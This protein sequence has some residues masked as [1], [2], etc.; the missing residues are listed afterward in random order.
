MK[1]NASSPSPDTAAPRRPF[2]CR[3]CGEPTPLTLWGFNPLGRFV[4][5]RSCSA[6]LRI[7]THARTWGFGALFL[8]MVVELLFIRDRGLW[9][10]RGFSGL[11]VQA[12]LFLFV[13]FSSSLAGCLV[14][15]K[16][17]SA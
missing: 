11:F 8:V 4:F 13:V 2:E 3:N 16:F 9:D 7:P 1:P 17:A 5:C 10:P 6:P 12:A 14:C 15:R